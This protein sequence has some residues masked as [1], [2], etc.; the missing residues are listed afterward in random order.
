MNFVMGAMFIVLPAMWMAAFGWAGIRVGGMAEMFSNG[1]KNVQSAA[2][3]AG[4]VASTNISR[5]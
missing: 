1:A 4:D 5:K 2:G 3:K